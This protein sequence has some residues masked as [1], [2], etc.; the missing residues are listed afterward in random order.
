MLTQESKM[1]TAMEVSR[2]R[3]DSKREPITFATVKPR[4]KKIT[5]DKHAD[6]IWTRINRMRCY[7]A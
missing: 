7:E 6:I 1:I 2:R 3:E 4:N 5:R